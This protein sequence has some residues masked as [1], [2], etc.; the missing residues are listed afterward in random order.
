LEDEE[1]RKSIKEAST[2]AMVDLIRKVPSLV[3]TLV[4]GLI[5]NEEETSEED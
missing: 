2:R 4:N 5:G 3:E 1:S